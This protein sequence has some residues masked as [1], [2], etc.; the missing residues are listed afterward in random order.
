MRREHWDDDAGPGEA[1]HA[2]HVHTYVYLNDA[3]GN[4]NFYG[5]CA[6]AVPA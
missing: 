4:F 2:E 5:V 1:L 6:E 3:V